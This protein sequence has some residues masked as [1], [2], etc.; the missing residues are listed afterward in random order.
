MKILY[1][2]VFVS[3]ACSAQEVTTTLKNYEPILEND[4]VRVGRAELG[5]ATLE[6]EEARD[7]LDELVMGCN[8]RIGPRG[9]VNQ[10]TSMPLRSRLLHQKESP[11]LT[12]KRAR[13][14]FSTTD[15]RKNGR[16]R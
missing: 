11:S 13:Y 3:F 9:G 2:A 7:H 12:Y 16:A 1:V 15:M 8:R 5:E 6:G 10:E 14:P 4:E